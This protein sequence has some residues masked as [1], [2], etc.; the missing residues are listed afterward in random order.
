MFLYQTTESRGQE[1]TTRLIVLPEDVDVAVGC[2]M[3]AL[4][5]TDISALT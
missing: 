5:K 3:S 4:Y 2:T 1:C